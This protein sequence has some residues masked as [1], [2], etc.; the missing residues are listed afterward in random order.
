MS[1]LA[2]REISKS[3]GG[4]QALKGVSFD[5]TRD[6]IVGIMGANGAGKTTLFGLIAGH[7]RPNSGEITFD[8]QRLGG[9]RP[10]QVCRAGVTRTFQIVRPLRALSALENVSTAALFGASPAGSR[11]AADNR[12][13]EILSEIGLSDQAEQSA[14]T[15]T[16]SAQKRLEVARAVATSPRLLLLD[17]VM[18]GLTPTE[19]QDMLGM[20]RRLK[21]K[22]G[23][24]ILI[25]E[26][27]MR[28]LMEL[29]DRII[30]LHHGDMIAQGLPKEV[31]AD[32][33]V[34]KAYIGTVA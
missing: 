2:I 12:A 8:G 10:D 24:T 7:I 15:L 6:E 4:V 13:H 16:L 14:G 11:Q 33:L 26:H 32:P 17:E 30:V 29:S 9:L 25:I 28:A 1:L 31:A 27:V 23:L 3:F 21:D 22:Y 34:L 20:I 18:A 19:I 5:V